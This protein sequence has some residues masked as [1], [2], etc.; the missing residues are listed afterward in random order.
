MTEARRWV[1]LWAPDWPVQAAV[2]SGAVEA[3]VPVAL[4]HAG[5]VQTASAEARAAGVRRGMRWREA[6][7]ACPD[8]ARVPADR[9][10]DARCFEPVAAALEAEVPGVE[11]LRPGLALAPAAGAARYWGGDHALARHLADA[12]G[13]A[14]ETAVGR[15]GLGI[16]DGPL[17]AVLAART[18]RIVAPGGSAAFLGPL[19]IA[20]LSLALAGTARAQDV[21]AL[22]SLLARLGVRTLGDFGALPAGAVGARFGEVGGYA[23]RL[24]IGLDAPGG[25]PFTPQPVFEQVIAPDDPIRDV[26]QAAFCARRLAVRLHAALAAHGAA[27]GRL[28]VRVRS[29]AGREHTRTWR[30]QGVDAG[31]V[32]DRVRW[33]LEAWLTAP[34]AGRPGQREESD[35]GGADGRGGGGPDALAELRLT[36]LDVHPAGLGSPGLWGDGGAAGERA[37]RA[38]DRVQGLLGGRGVYQAVEQG[39]RDPRGRIRLV[40]WGDEPRAARPLERPWPGRLPDPA[41]AV[42]PAEPVPVDVLD[43][44][45]RPVVAG[46]DGSISAEPARV[47]GVPAPE[48]ENAVVLGAPDPAVG[49]AGRTV[50]RLLGKG[51]RPGVAVAGWAGPWPVWERWWTGAPAQRTYVQVQLD[52]PAGR[53]LLL[54]AP[55]PP[56]PPGWRLEGLYA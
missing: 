29:V 15:I 54:A 55:A 27:Y 30:L 37:A 35:G 1:A 49:A 48:V 36:A 38:A 34:D 42:V 7:A 25:D 31:G 6:A 17:A 5:R 22:L 18:G 9:G 28:Q 20:A 51:E 13:G 24:A 43:G 52:E 39:G 45:G 56:Q 44:A 53:A 26:G 8:L 23:R 4:L 2:G 12:L 33:Q 10:R 46:A 40:P 14:S 41:P 47:V 21:A 19:P 3:G 32:A 16:A 50:A 11:L